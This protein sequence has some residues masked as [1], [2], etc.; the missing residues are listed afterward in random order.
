MSWIN[1]IAGFGTGK[2]LPFG[3]AP[4]RQI[5]VLFLVDWSPWT[6]ISGKN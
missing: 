5:C 4:E 6:T 3:G 2:I 1:Q